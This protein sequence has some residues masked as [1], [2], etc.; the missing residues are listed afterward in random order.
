MP[1]FDHNFN[2]LR[3]CGR[4]YSPLHRVEQDAMGTTFQVVIAGGEAD[5]ARKAALDAFEELNALDEQLSAFSET[6]DVAQVNALQPGEQVRVGAALIECLQLA[7]QVH[8]ATGGAFD[9]TAAA[10]LGHLR[11]EHA[12]ATTPAPPDDGG[13]T[14]MGRLVIDADA[15]TVGLSAGRANLELGAIGKGYAADRM[16]D[17][18]RAWELEGVL[19]SAGESTVRVMGFSHDERGCP[20]ALRNPR[21]QAETVGFARLGDNA[22]SGSGRLLR[23]DHIVDPRTGSPATDRLAA[24]AVA[25]TAAEA[26]A[27][28]TAMMVLDRKE[29]AELSER[30]GD[31][32]GMVFFLAGEAV[33]VVSFGSAIEH[34]EEF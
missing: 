22:V 16:I 26:D 23:G 9:V 17:R 25:D 2:T 5:Y 30:R 3:A 31:L 29:L 34:F 15:L 14:G 24:W 10:S 28:S 20:V 6:S 19:L 8:E 12:A 13:Q 21:R 32:S 18:L 7:R 27:M 33:D 1:G 11:D 4:F